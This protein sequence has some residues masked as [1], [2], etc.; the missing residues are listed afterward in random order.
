MREPIEEKVKEEVK[1]KASDLLNG[2]F[3]KKKKPADTTK[4]N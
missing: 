4:V 1:T 2:F 3:N